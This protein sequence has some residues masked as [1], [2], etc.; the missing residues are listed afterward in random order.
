M[1][2]PRAAA[3]LTQSPQTGRCS[4]RARLSQTGSTESDVDSIWISRLRLDRG[5]TSYTFST[6]GGATRSQRSPHCRPPTLSCPAGGA[7]RPQQLRAP[8]PDRGSPQLVTQTAA[9]APDKLRHLRRTFGVPP[10][11]CGGSAAA[12]RWRRRRRGGIALAGGLLSL[13]FRGWVRARRRVRTLH[14]HVLR[15][16]LG[17]LIRHLVCWWRLPPCLPYCMARCLSPCRWSLPWSSLCFRRL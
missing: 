8:P 6:T 7:S 13:G 10:G 3:G 1:S 16:T 5:M 12:W 17:H 11:G 15:R 9:G 4:W 2:R 14:N